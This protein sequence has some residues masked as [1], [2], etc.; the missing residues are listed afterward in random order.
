MPF[1]PAVLR[2]ASAH[3]I[4]LVPRKI[5]F[6]KRQQTECSLSHSISLTQ[7]LS[8][9]YKTSY[10]SSI[11][12]LRSHT[13]CIYQKAR[14]RAQCKRNRKQC[15]HRQPSRCVHLLRSSTTLCGLP[16]SAGGH[17]HKGTFFAFRKYRILKIQLLL[18]VSV[19]TLFV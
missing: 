19:R 11:P 4:P 5:T 3:Y 14:T 9:Q 12:F 7:P 8:F 1:A 10:T 18:A 16:V 2:T 17:F 6:P 13:V 15:K